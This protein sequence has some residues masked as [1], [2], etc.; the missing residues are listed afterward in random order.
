MLLFNP[1]ERALPSEFIA[2]AALTTAAEIGQVVL[3][4]V[5]ATLSVSFALIYA[6][7]LIYGP[8]AA[9]WIAGLGT[10]T[11]RQLRLQIPLKG[12]VFNRGQLV[13]SVLATWGAYFA[14]GGDVGKNPASQP[15]VAIVGGAVA[16]CIAN[17]TLASWYLALA[18]RVSAWRILT[19]QYMHVLPNFAVEAMMGYALATMYPEFGAGAALLMVVPLMLIRFTLQR[20][21]DRR[22]LMARTIRMFGR[23][24][25]AK[26]P[27]TQEHSLRVAA[28]AAALA[29]RLSFSEEKAER[30]EI[31]GL[32]HDIGKLD[33]RTAVLTKTGKLT[34]HEFE[35][36]KRH[37]FTGA[38][39]LRGIPQLWDLIDPVR[40]HHERLDGRGYPDRL[41]EGQVCLETRI[42]TVADAF[43]AMTSNRAYR[44]AMAIEKALE[45][46]RRYAGTQFDAQVVEAMADLSQDLSPILASVPSMGTRTV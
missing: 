34:D 16:Y 6:S 42:M 27:Y 2:F 38:E 11:L 29:R 4:R 30:I 18:K 7:F 24:L 41:T 39:I 32:L 45:E 36:I 35:E 31:A 23:V 43:D 9:V 46:L 40:H 28:Y 44:D 1:L 20:Y 8:S 25:E 19:G 17:F 26:D 3:P 13:W 15:V 10:L 21:V 33:T 22:N 5:Q 37:P 14:L 12:I